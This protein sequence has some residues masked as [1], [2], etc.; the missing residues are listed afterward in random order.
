M[1]LWP[2]TLTFTKTSNLSKLT[3]PQLSP[4][5]MCINQL[6]SWCKQP[7]PLLTRHDVTHITLSSSEQSPVCLATVLLHRHKQFNWRCLSACQLMWCPA[8]CWLS[9][10]IFHAQ[11]KDKRDTLYQSGHIRELAWSMEGTT[12]QVA[13]IWRTVQMIN[14]IDVSTCQ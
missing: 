12:K 2:I 9:V 1:N 7:H 10:S 6:S 13:N 5:W 11:G 14:L 4:Y 3:L 8:R